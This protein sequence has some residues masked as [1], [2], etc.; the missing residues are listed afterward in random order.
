VAGVLRGDKSRFQLFG[1]TM[2]T[3]SRMESTGLPNRIQVSQQTA[4]LITKFGKDKWL[5]PR[6]NKV[7]AKGK[8]E[9]QTYWLTPPDMSRSGD[10]ISVTSKSSDSE[11]DGERGAITPDSKDLE[12]KRSRVAEWTVEV[13]ASV[14]KAIVAARQS[15]GIKA[16]GRSKLQSMENEIQAKNSIGSTVIQEVAEAIALPDYNGRKFR[17]DASVALDAIVVSELRNYVQTIAGQWLSGP[18]NCSCRRTWWCRGWTNN[19][20]SLVVSILLTQLSSLQSLVGLTS[21]A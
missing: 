11:F 1:D 10:N 3:A 6:E 17:E 20:L 7:T 14:L 2:N 13:L 4:D 18:K 16:E 21:S 19:C 5:V 8:G 12:E 15:H 9:L